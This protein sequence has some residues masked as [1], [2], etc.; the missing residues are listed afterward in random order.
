M[1]GVVRAAQNRQ[2]QLLADARI[3][4]TAGAQSYS[5]PAGTQYINIELFGGGGGGGAANAVTVS[6]TNYYVGGGGGGGGGYVS[7]GYTGAF[8]GDVLNFT[9]G[10]GGTGNPTARGASGGNTLLTSI[11]R[12]GSTVIS[13]S[14]VVA[15]GG[16]GGERATTISMI[17]RGGTGGQATG[18]NKNNRSGS[19]GNN[20]GLTSTSGANGGNGGAGGNNDENAAEFIIPANGGAGGLFSTDTRAVAGGNALVEL[21]GAGGGGGGYGKLFAPADANRGA[22]GG[23]GGIRIRAYG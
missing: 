13:F 20:G 22:T 15:Y 6:R 12:N 7:Y 18:A 5:I 10:S 23:T 11:T 3:G 17:P 14:N 8:G 16:F 4:T 2:L 1:I 21:I 9:I 19:N